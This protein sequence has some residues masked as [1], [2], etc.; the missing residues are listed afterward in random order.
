MEIC[1]FSLL[2]SSI[3]LIYYILCCLFMEVD[4]FSAAAYGEYETIDELLRQVRI[5]KS[6]LI[7]VYKSR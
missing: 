6:L 3:L 2:S 4:L 7:L 5:W 1:I